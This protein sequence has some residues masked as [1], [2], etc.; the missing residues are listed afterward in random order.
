MQRMRWAPGLAA[1]VLV[2]ASL[3]SPVAASPPVTKCRDSKDAAHRFSMTVA[4]EKATGHYTLPKGKARGLL[5][6]AHGYGHTSY[7]WIDHM[8]RAAANHGLIAVGMDYRGTKIVPDENDDGLPEG[9]GWRVMTGAEDTVAAAKLFSDTCKV[10]LV[11]L[12]SVSMGSNTGGLALALAGE[13]GITRRA[14]KPLFDYW[15]NVEGAVNLLETYASA[16]VLAPVNEYAARAQADIEEETGGAFE[17]VPD[18][19][20]ERTVVARADD[21]VAS[22]VRGVVFVHGV[23]D[24]LIPYNQSRELAAL[25]G[26]HR[27]PLDVL[28]V[29]RKDADSERETTA[30][31]YVGGQVDPEYRSPFAGHASE[32]STTHIVM[33]TSFA[34]TW[35]LFTGE[36]PGP[37][38]EY[39]VDG[40][41]GTFGPP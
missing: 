19:Y 23:D 21:V 3:P 18:A 33:T 39:L 12:M 2:A 15:M 40:E 22:G 37:Y 25:L 16:R 4:G 17:E 38:R 30:T 29:L 7:S 9:R 6:V 8:R 24:G 1:G 20:M 5:V 41:A 10:P 26:A 32:K 31:G 36:E 27:V 34:R 14:G 28:T 35:S 13:Q 11:V